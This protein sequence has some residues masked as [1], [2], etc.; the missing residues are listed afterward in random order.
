MMTKNEMPSHEEQAKRLMALKDRKGYGVL[1][2][3]QAAGDV[4]VAVSPVPELAGYEIVSATHE[5]AYDIWKDGCI[6]TPNQTK[7]QIQDWIQSK[8]PKWVC[9]EST[10]TEEQK[11]QFLS[12]VHEFQ[13]RY[14]GVMSLMQ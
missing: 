3:I 13:R 7:E 5:C 10:P 8:T 6:E 9:D 4:L 1:A 14:P 11:K 12:W 2:I